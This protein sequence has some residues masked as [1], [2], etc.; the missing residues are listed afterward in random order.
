MARKPARRTRAVRSRTAAARTR[1]RVTAANNGAPNPLADTETLGHSV[2]YIHGIGSQAPASETKRSWDTALF[3]QAMF[4]TSIAY[5][6][7]IRHPVRTGPGARNVRALD[8]ALQG[9]EA[10]RFMAALGE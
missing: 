3:G 1:R 6:A 10:K 9:A 2:V 7:D 5:W 8:R 4:D